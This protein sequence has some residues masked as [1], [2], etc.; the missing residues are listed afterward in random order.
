MEPNSCVLYVFIVHRSGFVRMSTT[1]TNTITIARIAYIS[2]QYVPQFWKK[3]KKRVHEYVISSSSLR[4]PWTSFRARLRST[5][6]NKKEKYVPTH[7]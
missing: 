2:V 5:E 7:E 4:L 1:I 6:Q 3:K